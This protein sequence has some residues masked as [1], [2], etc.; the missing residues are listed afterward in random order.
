[1]KEV[2]EDERWASENYFY[3]Y[4]YLLRVIAVNYPLSLSAMISKLYDTI[5]L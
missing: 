4:Y 2:K 5:Y 3:Y 1:M